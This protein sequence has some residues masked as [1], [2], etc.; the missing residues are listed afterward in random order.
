MAPTSEKPSSASTEN[1][2][3]VYSTELPF[4]VTVGFTAGYTYIFF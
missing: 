3:F 4:V 2:T 1:E